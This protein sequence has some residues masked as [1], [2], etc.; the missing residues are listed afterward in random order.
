[1]V[2]SAHDGPVRQGWVGAVIIRLVPDS[3]HP[4][5]EQVRS[6]IE[7]AI[8]NGALAAETRLPTVRQLADELGLAVNTVARSYRELEMAGLVETRGRHGSFVAPIDTK[9]R[10]QAMRTTR[11]YAEAMRRLGIGPHGTLALL[12]REL[13]DELAD[14]DAANVTGARS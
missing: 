10:R 8:E 4:P 3:P 14:D 13:A 6:Q 2:Q 7:E 5:Y 11:T 1:M 9:A 12:R